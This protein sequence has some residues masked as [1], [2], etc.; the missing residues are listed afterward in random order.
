MTPSVDPLSDLIHTY[1]IAARDP[2]SGQM[3]VAVQSH[4]FSVGPMCPW[5]EAGVGA[6]ATQSF[7]DPGY[8]PLGLDL[9]RTGKS[10]EEALRGLLAADE[11]EHR[12]QVA[13]IDSTGG[14]AAHTGR[15]CIAEAGHRTGGGFSV[16]ANMMLNNT[17]WDAMAET[18]VS[19]PGSLAQRMLGALVA[20]ETEGGDIRG[21]QS[22]AM[23][24]VNGESTGKPWADR[25]LELRVED[26]AQPLDEMQRLLTIHESYARAR[27]ISARIYQGA[28]LEAALADVLAMQAEGATNLELDFWFAVSL[29]A[30][31]KDS[32]AKKTLDRVF[33]ID[34]NWAELLRRLPAA[35]LL[36]IEDSRLELFAPLASTWSDSP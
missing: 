20:A 21:R 23:L 13:M 9:M 32:E 12:R 29:I 7:V 26:H 33:E 3:G 22:A 28:D 30:A 31:G 17:V 19:T 2:E 18:F 15:S 25:S 5:A 4:Y 10:A 14:V 6:V 27:E 11:L 34:P 1:S 8:G 36:E 24:I 16:Q 35:D